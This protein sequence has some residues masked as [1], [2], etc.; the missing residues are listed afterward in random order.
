MTK[1]FSF[2]AE[3][4]AKSIEHVG[5]LPVQRLDQPHTQRGVAKCP[6]CGGGNGS[7][8][9]VFGNVVRM[10][11]DGVGLGQP[12]DHFLLGRST[13][14]EPMARSEDAAGM[15]FITLAN[16]GAKIIACLFISTDGWFR[17]CL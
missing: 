8:R 13:W 7:D 17:T 5:R 4:A 10:I 3:L 1:E 16:R 15:S 12:R 9:P 2:K 11:D 6:R 14:D